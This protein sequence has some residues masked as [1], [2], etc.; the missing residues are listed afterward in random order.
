MTMIPD[1]RTVSS[2]VFASLPREA[3]LLR[4]FSKYLSRGETQGGV[5]CRKGDSSQGKTPIHNI[6]KG[7]VWSIDRAVNVVSFND[8]R[9]ITG[10]DLVSKLQ[11][12]MFSSYSP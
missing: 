5:S 10:L 7:V 9:P 6:M 1:I 3:T 2:F 4:F 12:A 11:F 8:M